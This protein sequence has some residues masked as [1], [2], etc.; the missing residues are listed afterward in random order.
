MKQ[1]CAARPRLGR[2]SRNFYQVSI[3]ANVKRERKHILWNILAPS[4]QSRAACHRLKEVVEAQG[5]LGE[6][7]ALGNMAICQGTAGLLMCPRN[8]TK[9]VRSS[10][11]MTK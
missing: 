2:A 4:G 11:I 6:M 9:L 7:S 1:N 5:S 10:I 8:K 3:F